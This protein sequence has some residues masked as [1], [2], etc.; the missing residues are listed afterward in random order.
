MRVVPGLP[1]H[2]RAVRAKC[3]RACQSYPGGP[4]KVSPGL[5]VIPGRSVQS[6]TGLVSHTRAVRAKCHRACQSYP[7]GPRKVP[8]GLSVI[9]GRSVQSVTGLPR[10]YHAVCTPTPHPRPGNDAPTQPLEDESY[11]RAPRFEDGRLFLVAETAPG[12]SSL[13]PVL[14]S[15]PRSRSGARGRIRPRPVPARCMD[16]T[17]GVAPACSR[18]AAPGWPRPRPRRP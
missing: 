11:S 5:S 12:K 17:S 7:G 18:G 9:P 8:P 6:V 1:R 13:R 2:Y 15:T 4:C 3:H 16:G 14:L 10:H